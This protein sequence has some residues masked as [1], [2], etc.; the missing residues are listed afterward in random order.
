LL[1]ALAAC[2][3]YDTGLLPEPGTGIA[4]NASGDG[5][6]PIAGNGTGGDSGDGGVC[7]QPDDPDNCG[8]CGVVCGDDEHCTAGV[9]HRI[10]IPNCNGAWCGDDGCG[11]RCHCPEGMY[12]EPF[13]N[14]CAISE[15]TDF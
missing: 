4:G 5:G 9:C 10:C 7:G 14:L 2:S 13:S 8:A 11:G 12:C 1:V 15:P 3:E 6:A